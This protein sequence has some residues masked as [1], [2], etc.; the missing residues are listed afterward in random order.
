MFWAGIVGR[1][2]VVPAGVKMTSEKNVTFMTDHFPS[3][4][5]KKNYAFHNEIVFMH[6]NGPSH[7]VEEYLCIIL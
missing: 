3:W 7:A 4:C 5:K 2:L 6:D 1:E